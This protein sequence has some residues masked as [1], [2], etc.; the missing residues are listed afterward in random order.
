MKFRK[1][2]LKLSGPILKSWAKYYFSKERNYQHQGIKG[3]I[4]P[5]VFFPHLTWS[6][7]ILMDHFATEDLKGKSF[8]ELGCGSG[9]ISV[10]AAKNGAKV[11][12]SDIYL[13]ATENAQLNAMRNTVEIETIQSDLFDEIPKQQFDFIVINPPYYPKNPTN[14]EEK[15]WF[16]GND[17]QYFQ[18]L[19]SQIHP[20][21]GSHS[22]VIMILSED[23]EIDR[24]K[25]MARD[26][27]LDLNQIKKVKNW[28]EENF[29]FQLECI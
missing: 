1:A 27:K 18:K 19:F 29:L 5:G 14:D 12:A 4:L 20:Y 22:K 21:F 9:L 23:C 28:A 7:S 25:G 26:N 16:C 10:L 3:V 15:A 2:L 6:T 8:L 17:F 11:T 24:I 13:K